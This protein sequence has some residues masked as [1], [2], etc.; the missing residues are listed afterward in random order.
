MKT[1][2]W[3]AKSD[4]IM[5]E[6]NDANINEN[7]LVSVSPFNAETNEWLIDSKKVMLLKEAEKIAI[8]STLR[9]F[10]NNKTQAAKVLGTSIRNFYYKLKKHNIN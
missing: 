6:C 3:I 1:K 10:N 9:K 5:I 8:I 2:D 4:A 7:S